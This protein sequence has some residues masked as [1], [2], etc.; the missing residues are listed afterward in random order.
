VRAFLGIKVEYSDKIAN[1]VDEI[2]ELNMNAKFVEPENLH[3][4]IKFFGE[5][6]STKVEKIISAVNEIKFDR[7]NLALNG[8]GV[9]PRV[10]TPRVVWIGVSSEELVRLFNILDEK[11][12]E[13]GMSK[14]QRK[15]TPHLT[16]CRI[17]SQVDKSKLDE[18]LNKFKSAEFGNIEVKEL[19]LFESKLYRDGPNYIPLKKF[20]L[21][22]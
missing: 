2:K 21:G 10:D 9:F 4:N 11:F 12:S 14:E 8:V 13:I 5:V 1:F 17:R 19:I 20:E 18:K 15:F 3:V 22:L 16:I 6:T 7:F